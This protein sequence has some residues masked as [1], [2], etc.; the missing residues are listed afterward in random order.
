MFGIKE[1]DVKNT[2]I[3]MPL[4]RKDMLKWLGVKGFSRGRLYSSGNST[5]FTVMHTGLG[6]ALLGDAVLYLGQTQ[7]Q[8]IILF[9]SCGSVGQEEDLKIGSLVTPGESYSLESFSDMLLKDTQDWRIF[10]GDKILLESFLKANEAHNIKK[11]TCLT[12]GSLKLEEDYAGLFKENEIQVVDMESSAFFS[13]SKHIGRKAMA[14]FYVTDIINKKPFY[15]PLNAQDKL[16]I[17][18]SIKSSANILCEFI[19]KNL[20]G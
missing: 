2:C 20:N 4:M 13:A 5:L 9:G 19:K 11:V 15:I 12:L 18:S 3:L 6:A 8:N 16:T 17:F 7:C 1:A 10:H 14:L